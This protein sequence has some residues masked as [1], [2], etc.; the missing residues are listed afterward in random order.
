MA[1]AEASYNIGARNPIS[2][3]LSPTHVVIGR[4]AGA[5]FDY[6][7]I[8][9]NA[10]GVEMTARSAIPVIRVQPLYRP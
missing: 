5:Q 1:N 3:T 8:V 6:G 9:E 2:P 10:Q 4:V 7:G